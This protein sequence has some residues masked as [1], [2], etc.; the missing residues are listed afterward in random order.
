MH[1]YQPFTKPFRVLQVI[2][3]GVRPGLGVVRARGLAAHHRPPR[4]CGNLPVQAGI[5]ALHPAPAAYQQLPLQSAILSKHS[6]GTSRL[7]APSH[8]QHTAAG[9]M[10]MLIV[11]VSCQYGADAPS[12]YIYITIK[13][14]PGC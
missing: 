7:P 5:L 12:T 13:L 2:M 10:H 1:T 8:I 9:C 3:V 4:A 11:K 14:P 6:I